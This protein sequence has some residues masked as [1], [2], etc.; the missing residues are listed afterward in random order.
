MDQIVAV[1]A[2]NVG[3]NKRFLAVWLS[4]DISNKIKIVISFDT[5][6]GEIKGMISL[7]SVRLCST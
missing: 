2:A 6:L 7:K 4:Q 5:V 3:M 1:G